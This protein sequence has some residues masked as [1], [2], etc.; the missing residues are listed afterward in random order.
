MSSEVAVIQKTDPQVEV[1]RS[2]K[3][4]IIA[5]SDNPILSLVV[6]AVL[7]DL[8]TRVVITDGAGGKRQILNP[9]QVQYL[10]TAITSLDVL[11]AMGGAQ[12]VTSVLSGIMAAL[13][14]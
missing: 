9:S 10:M 14:K 6:G 11:K 7:L 3:E 12:G 2:I 5:A 13:P 8:M 4:I 1:I